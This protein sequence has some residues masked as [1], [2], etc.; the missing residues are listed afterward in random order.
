VASR[1]IRSDF[2]PRRREGEP[3]GSGVQISSPRPLFL[4]EIV[5]LGVLRISYFRA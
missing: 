3:A 4:F 2:L 1:R 5:N